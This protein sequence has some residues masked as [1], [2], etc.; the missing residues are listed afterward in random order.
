MKQG[1]IKTAAALA[2]SLAAVCAAAQPTIS[3]LGTGGTIAGAAPSSTQLSGYTIGEVVVQNLLDAVPALKSIANMTGTQVFNVGSGYLTKGEWLK[4]AN[5]VQSEVDKDSVTG[6]VITHGTDTLEETA[7]FLNLVVST[8]KSV[9]LVGAMRPSTAISAD[10]P[11]NLLNAAKVAVA[12]ESA[13]RGVL[14]VMNDEIHAARDVTK[15]NTT[16]V[17]TFKSPNFGPIGYIEG[18]KVRYYREPF[19]RH[20]FQ[21]RFNIRKISDL[22]R[23]DILYS[24]VDD[25]GTLAA[26]SLKAGAQ[27][28]VHAGTGNGTVHINAF[29]VLADASRRGIPVIRTSR[30]GTGSVVPSQKIWTEAGFIEGGTLNPQKARILLQVALTQTK[31]KEEIRKIFSEY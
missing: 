28:V 10:G 2:V 26:A 3:V 7:Y 4:L 23:V 31:D 1:A 14:L 21:S 25:D 16:N 29:E 18:G 17:A 12:P 27:G 9:V 20:T 15:T 5:A 19:G 11:L 13:G 8:K 22:P 6:V 30:V 24:H